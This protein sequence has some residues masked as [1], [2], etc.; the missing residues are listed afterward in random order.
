MVRRINIAA[1]YSNVQL[2]KAK[3][4]QT[5]YEHRLKWPNPW[6]GRILPFFNCVD[7]YVPNFWH[8]SVLWNKPFLDDWNLFPWFSW[9]HRTSFYTVDEI[10]DFMSNSFSFSLLLK[11]VIPLW[12]I[13][14][15]H[16]VHNLRLLFEVGR[17]SI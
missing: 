14:E 12:K 15:R 6:E 4:Y 11:H 16:S 10:I 3:H 7:N 5:V 1:K 17:D 2:A 9:N 8:F 13:S